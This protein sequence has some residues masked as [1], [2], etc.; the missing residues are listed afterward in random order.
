MDSSCLAPLLLDV[1]RPALPPELVGRL[2][3]WEELAE[4]E[5]ERARG[6]LELMAGLMRKPQVTEWTYS[7]TT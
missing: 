1:A 5:R 7:F 2:L 6:D 3:R 4:E